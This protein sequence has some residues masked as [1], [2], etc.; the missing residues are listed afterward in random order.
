MFYILDVIFVV[1]HSIQARIHATH[2]VHSCCV[3]CPV[4]SV[5]LSSLFQFFLLCIPSLPPQFFVVYI[6]LGQSNGQ[7]ELNP[8]LF[9]AELPPH[10]LPLLF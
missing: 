5:F 3:H 7:R 8:F 1:V 9:Q 2:V 6:L 4:L 10:F